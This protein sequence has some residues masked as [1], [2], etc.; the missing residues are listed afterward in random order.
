MKRVMQAVMFILIV[1]GLSWGQVHSKAYVMNGLAETLDLINLQ[2]GVVT[3]NVE[4]LGLYP[5]QIIYHG[6]HLIVVNSGYNN[7]QVIDATSLNTTGTVEFGANH[8]PYNIC[9]LADGRVAVSQ[10]VDNSVSI[11]NVDSMREEASIPVGTGPEGVIQD[12][13]ELFVAITNYVGGYQPGR[14]DVINLSSHQVT[15]HIAV[16]IN[17]QWIG[18]GQ[19]GNLQVLCTGDYATIWG[20]VYVVNPSTHQVVDTVAVGSSPGSWAMMTSGIAY[21]GVSMWGGGGYL[22]AYNTVSHQVLHSESNPLNVGGGVMG[23]VAGEDSR[24]YICVTENDRVKVMDATESIIATY[25]VGDGPQSIALSPPIESAPPHVNVVP[26]QVY[27]EQN[28]PNPFNSVTIIPYRLPDGMVTSHL[29]I[30]NLMGQQVRRIS[31]SGDGMAVWDG[32][33]QNGVAVGAGVY[34][35]RLSGVEGLR[36]IRAVYLP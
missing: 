24:L 30:V 28:Y 31:V 12:G 2:T 1:V 32:K 6:R 10:L 34:W 25:N 33:N 8:N 16:G 20:K 18:L 26:R 22:L 35:V 13:S 19:D 21:L 36:P 11:V 29:E 14:V 7:L 17:P 4:P 5:N 15:D 3:P 23:L 9:T 27:L